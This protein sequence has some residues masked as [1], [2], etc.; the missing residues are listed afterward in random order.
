MKNIIK[1]IYKLI[2]FK[3]HLFKILRAFWIPTK[4]IR[5][6]LRFNGIVKINILDDLSFKMISNMYTIENEFFWLGQSNKWERESL[7]I[8]KKL[9][10]GKDIIFD[11]GANTGIYSLIAKTINT[12]CKVYA[13][14]PQPN[15][16][17]SLS[18]NNTL[19]Q[20]DIICEPI[21]LSNIN[22]VASFFNYGTSAFESNSTAGSLNKSHRPQNQSSIKVNCQTL[23]SYITTNKLSKIDLMKIDVET[24]EVEV[25]EGMK[26]YLN[27]FKPIIL[28]EIIDNTVGEKISEI[29]SKLGY[30]FFY[31]DEDKGIFNVKDLKQR[32]HN[33]YI[34]SQSKIPV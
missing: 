9:C 30:N 31:I 18:E 7:N 1:R 24:H 26:D 27:K 19:N 11:I 6:L 32:K 22:G 10:I 28:I 33:N 34:L 20:F 3:P 17:K 4:K 13:F 14:E 29:F 23:E 2:P 21:A 12:D 5:S 16:Y 15:I 8:W 25:L